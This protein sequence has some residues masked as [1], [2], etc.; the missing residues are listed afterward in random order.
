MGALENNELEQQII[1]TAKRLFVEKGFVET[2]MSDIAATVGINRPTL[3]YYFRTKDRM[4]QAV[5]SS[6]VMSLLP[7]VREIMKRDIPFMERVSML[8][9]EYLVRF[10]ENP[11]IPKFIC[12]EVQRDVNHLL[13]TAKEM[14][15][16]ETFAIIKEG[17]Q[18]EM[19]AGR[20]KTVPLH[21][22]FLTFYGL[23]LFPLLSKNL[24][25]TLF[26]KEDSEFEL[27]LWEWKQY[28]LLHL[29]NLLCVDG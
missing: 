10:I 25:V 4:F 13:A 2:S 6:I 19:E 22:L 15:F 26:L 9:D 18:S 28:I 1:E 29:K 5:F 21:I 20:L 3:H 16:E 11:Y 7:R 8:L 27:L 14:Q 17:L 24:V 12:E 23:L